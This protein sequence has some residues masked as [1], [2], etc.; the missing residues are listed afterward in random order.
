MPQ[1]K[2]DACGWKELICLGKQLRAFPV[3]FS[4]VEVTVI[5]HG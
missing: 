2:V 4:M 3:T 1:Q 5:I